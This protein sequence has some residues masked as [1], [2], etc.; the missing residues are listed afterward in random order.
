MSIFTNDNLVLPFLATLGA[1]VAVIGMQ[2]IFRQIHEKRQKLY[3]SAYILDVAYRIAYSEITLKRHTIEPHIEATERMAKGDEELIN[4]AFLTDEFDILKAPP[5]QFTHLPNEYQLLIG[6][7]DIEIV[8]MFNTLLYLHENDI[9]REDLNSYVKKH[10]KS[11]HDFL[12]YT[13]E[14]Q[15]DLLFTYHDHLTSLNHE[16]TRII[17]FVWEMILPKIKAYIKQFQ[18]LLFSTKQARLNIQK[19]ETLF[20]ENSDLLPDKDYMDK[21]KMGGIQ[22]EL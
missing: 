3:S 12:Q 15:L 10:L 7:D 16:S 21:V 5:M 20:N 13:P 17:V 6:G 1:S 8:Q 14:K 9:N 18:F 19:L 22:G 4:N 2:F 11:V